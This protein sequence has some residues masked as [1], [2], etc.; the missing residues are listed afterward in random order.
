MS[1]AIAVYRPRDIPDDAWEVIGPFVRTAVTQCEGKTPH[2]AQ[3]ML[4]TA[5]GLAYWCWKIAG[6]PLEDRYAFRHD[7][8]TS[9]TNHLFARGEFTNATVATYRSTLMRMADV[10]MGSESTTYRLPAL[11]TNKPVAPFDWEQQIALRSWAAGQATNGRRIGC[12]TLLAGALGAGLSATELLELTAA[13]VRTDAEGVLLEVGGRRPRTVPVLAEWESTLADIASAS[14]KPEQWIFLPSRTTCDVNQVHRLIRRSN[15]KPFPINAQRLRSTWI[16][17]HLIAGVPVQAILDASGIETLSGLGRFLEFAPGVDPTEAR[18]L[19]AHPAR[20]RRRLHGTTRIQGRP[21][22]GATLIEL[23]E[24]ERRHLTMLLDVESRSDGSSHKGILD[25]QLVDGMDRLVKVTG[26][27]DRYAEWRNAAKGPGGRPSAYG[28]NRDRYLIVIMLCLLRLGESPQLIEVADVIRNRLSAESRKLLGLPVDNGRASK[29]AIYHRIVRAWKRFTAVC[30]PFPGATHL[31]MTRAE[32][33]KIKKGFDP[34]EVAQRKARLH[35]VQNTLLEATWMLLDEETRRDWQGNISMD[36]T[37]VFV[38]GKRGS[39]SR[40]KKPTDSM[41]PEIMCDWH[42]MNGDPLQWAYSLHIATAVPGPYRKGKYPI[43]AIAASMGTHAV[44]VGKEFA[45]LL[46]SV[47]ERGHPVGYAIADRGILGQA[48]PADLNR[49]AIE[50]G[51][52]LVM[53]YKKSIKKNSSGSIQG[54]QRG[55]VYVDGTAF[56]PATPTDLVDA[57]STFENDGDW[58]AFRDRIARRTMYRFRKKDGDAYFC[59]AMGPGATAKCGARPE[60][61]L[62][63]GMPTT[64]EHVVVLDPPAEDDRPRC[65]TGGQISLPASG[66]DAEKY[67]QPLVYK[68]QEWEDVYD[69]RSLVEGYNGYA[70]DAKK[71]DVEEPSNRRVRGF[72]ANALIAVFALAATNVRKIESWTKN[73]KKPVGTPKP[74]P[75]KNRF[76]RVPSWV[77]YGKKTPQG[78]PSQPGAD[79]PAEPVPRVA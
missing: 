31:R 63:L 69:L 48:M 3:I 34:D 41:S 17:T 57:R 71:E 30:D 14:W 70:K 7:I 25:H 18:S 68:T 58:Q 9:Y 21:L 67:L 56:C 79:P 38:W 62:Q 11:R 49:P 59:P 36:S 19:R 37:A 50:L 52:E 53:D 65:C 44:D 33:E 47:A 16:V 23:S 43:L 55:V 78:R 75:V 42:Y 27:L 5:A 35:E 4:G 15:D 40:G 61:P 10:L 39:R 13:D 1:D 29:V 12:T 8:I 32:V 51:Y 22:Q 60:G 72:G 73:G 77:K 54:T 66:T 74:K 76:T 20:P 6:I 64:R 45:G 46:R 2:K 26:I 28:E 24:N